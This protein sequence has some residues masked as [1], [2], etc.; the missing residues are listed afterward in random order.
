MAIKPRNQ[1]IAFDQFASDFDRVCLAPPLRYAHALMKFANLLSGMKVLEL[2]CG[3]G[4]FAI[5]LANSGLDVTG[6]DIS[7]AMLEIADARA[8]KVKVTWLQAD[9]S[10]MNFDPNQ[11]HC[12]FSF[13]SFHLFD[14]PPALI[15]RLS[16]SLRPGGTLAI[17]WCDYHWEAPLQ[18]Q[19]RKQFSLAGIEWGTWGYQR[20]PGFSK[21]ILASQEPFTKLVGKTIANFQTWALF[22]IA[23]YLTSIEKVAHL[24]TPLR[25]QLRDA[26]F[27]ELRKEIGKSSISGITKYYICGNRYEP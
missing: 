14:D 19:I 26:L 11:Y 17:G 7:R 25:I 1:N 5:A 22:D 13:E 24:S 27:K 3:S 12:I 15:T 20:A 16:R 23:V 6:V 9:V 2:G 10:R 4:A 8:A 18:G 21:A